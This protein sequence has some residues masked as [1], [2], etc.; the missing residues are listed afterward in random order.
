MYN[1]KVIPDCKKQSKLSVKRLDYHPDSSIPRNN[2]Q[3]I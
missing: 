3:I 2:I 1:Y